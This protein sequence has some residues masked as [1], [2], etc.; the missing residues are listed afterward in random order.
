[1]DG[2]WNGRWSGN[3]VSTYTTQ[4][5]KE[6]PCRK[7]AAVILELPA[8]ADDV[9]TVRIQERED[10]LPCPVLDVVDGARRLHGKGLVS[11]SVNS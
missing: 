8:V 9:L 1:M 3:G 7:S 6:E 4:V 5:R 11:V 2:V 10:C